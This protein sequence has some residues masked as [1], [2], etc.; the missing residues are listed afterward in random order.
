MSS[1]RDEISA[2]RA[3]DRLFSSDVK[4]NDR[5]IAKELRDVATLL[6]TRQ[7]DKRKLFASPNIFTPLYCLKMQEVPLAECCDYTSPLSIARSGEKLPKVAEGTYGLLIQR[8]TSLDGQKKFK[9]STPDRYANLLRLNMRNK[10]LFYWM[11][12]GY[13][14]VTNPDTR[15]VNLDGYFEEDVPNHLLYP[16][17]DCDCK[18]KPKKEDSCR[19]PLD[20]PFRC[21]GYLLQDV[22]TLVRKNLMETYFKTV[23]DSTKDG[24]DS[25]VPNK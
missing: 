7:T 15:A 14:Y 25:Q 8:V 10:D 21:P 5:S 24:V 18:P 4:L 6:V 22:K 20:Q 13:L 3:M 19:N 17:A 1:I 9:E 23:E 2:I 12:N 11:H 16:G